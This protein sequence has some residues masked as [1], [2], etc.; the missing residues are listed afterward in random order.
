[1]RVATN[2]RSSR[3][4][5]ESMVSRRSLAT[6]TPSQ[7]PHRASRHHRTTSNTKTVQAAAPTAA[8][9]EETRKPKLTRRFV[10]PQNKTSP[11]DHRPYSNTSLHG[12][13][14]TK[15]DEHA[16][17]YR[18]KTQ[19]LALKTRRVLHKTKLP[20]N[21]GKIHYIFSTCVQPL[22]RLQPRYTTRFPSWEHGSPITTSYARTA[23]TPSRFTKGPRSLGSS[24]RFKPRTTP[25]TRSKKSVAAGVITDRK[26]RD[27]PP[28][29][30]G[31]R[32]GEGHSSTGLDPT[33][34][35]RSERLEWMS[36]R[37]S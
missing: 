17:I 29:R 10:R 21:F 9:L 34:S 31:Q 36:A 1:M 33:S 22:R 27:S 4:S 14:P 16:S 37:F 18:P 35:L 6:E 8:C 7:L 19:K 26:R 23:Q 28:P 12:I 25:P 2:S 32:L 13:N 11:V 20:L 15:T 3:D 5:P 30:I 24:L